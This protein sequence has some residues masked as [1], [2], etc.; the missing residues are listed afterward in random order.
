MTN[1]HSLLNIVKQYHTAKVLIIGD[2]MLDRFVHGEV[3]RISPE[4]PIPILKSKQENRMI[5]GAGNVL[6]NLHGLK[7]QARLVGIV[8]EDDFGSIVRG[9]AEA[10]GGHSEDLFTRPQSPTTVKIRFLAGHQQLLR[11]DSELS[12]YI[13]LDLENELC[14]HITRIIPQF[15]AII[16]SD[17]GK[18]CLTDRVLRCVIDNAKAYKI[19]VLVDPK[20]ND[21]SKYRGADIVTPNRKELSE[22]TNN[23]AT[24]NDSDIV[25]AAQK[26]I[27]QC[28]ICAVIATRSQDGMSV[29]T[30]NSEK[31]A[32]ERPVHLRTHA[33]EVFDVSGAGDTVIATIAAGL[34]TGASLL[35]S[36]ALANIAGG[37]VVG[38]VGTAPIRQQDL[39]QALTRADHNLEITPS[40]DFTSLDRARRAPLCQWDEALEQV[41]RWRARGLKIGFTNGCFDIMHAGHVN[42][43]NDARNYCDRLVL[44]LNTDVAVSLLKGPSRPINDQISRAIVLGALGSIDMVVFFGAEHAKDDSTASKLIQHL[45]PDIYFKGADYTLEQIPEVPTVRSYGGEVKLIP[46]THGYS[47]THIIEQIIKPAA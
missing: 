26:L 6:S 22:A 2:V 36:V 14:D 37:I 29:I 47:T 23:S 12:R 28:G 7:V 19:P 31:T 9:L 38:K 21:Y 42:Y 25:E 43:L 8:G 32:F 3:E 16:L 13:D 27:N 44:G 17:Y 46:L 35:D 39:E 20:G 1:T 5:G 40:G 15:G 41:N 4:G 45:Q 11:V 34:A 10:A 24:I 18:G 33:Q 30:Q